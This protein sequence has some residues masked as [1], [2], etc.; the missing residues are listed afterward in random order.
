MYLL[1]N[2]MVT[3]IKWYNLNEVTSIFSE[4]QL[5]HRARPEHRI[6]S[7]VKLLESKCSQN[8]N[9][10]PPILSTQWRIL[11]FVKKWLVSNVKG[12][13]E[14]TISKIPATDQ[15][16]TLASPKF[17][18]TSWTQ[19]RKGTG[20]HTQGSCS[21]QAVP[22]GHGKIVI[23]HYVVPAVLQFARYIGVERHFLVLFNNT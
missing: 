9:T 19:R 1:N 5:W 12:G 16:E 13:Q 7:S 6:T 18:N 20:P 10:T 4:S 17:L 2:L 11:E 22:I 23:Q 21:L 3:D 8:F 15:F 14:R